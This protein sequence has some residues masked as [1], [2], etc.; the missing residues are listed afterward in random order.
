MTHTAGKDQVVRVDGASTAATKV[1]EMTFLY[2]Q[3]AGGPQANFAKS[4]RHLAEI[5]ADFE[6]NRILSGKFPYSTEQAMKLHAHRMAGGR[7]PKF[8][9]EK[10]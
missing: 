5:G 3:C 10:Q 8:E 4:F 2:Q 6:K 9:E 7:E 1:D